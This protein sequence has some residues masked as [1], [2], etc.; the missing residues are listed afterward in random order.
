VKPR[1]TATRNCQ[2]RY[3]R[4][5]FRGKP[6]CTVCGATRLPSQELPERP[7]PRSRFAR[8][9]KPKPEKPPKPA[10][11]PKPERLPKEPK[12][13]KPVLKVIP[14][15]KILFRDMRMTDA[16]FDLLHVYG[17]GSASAGLRKIL[18][19]FGPLLRR[20]LRLVDDEEP[21]V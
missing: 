14:E 1:P 5:K 8:I 2:G 7:F 19:E 17:D 20:R 11:Q 6:R 12:P 3:R 15:P 9:D 16:D 4:H 21:V 13:P 10:K 18:E